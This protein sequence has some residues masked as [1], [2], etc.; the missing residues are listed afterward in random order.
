M[1]CNADALLD[2]AIRFPKLFGF[3]KACRLHAHIW[4]QA[5]ALETKLRQFAYSAVCDFSAI[6][7]T[8][9]YVDRERVRNPRS[10]IS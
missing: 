7:T 5:V 4:L 9:D 8:V 6:V 2:R 10:F 3:L 1:W